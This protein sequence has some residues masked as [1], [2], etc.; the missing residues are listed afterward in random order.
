VPAFGDNKECP[1]YQIYGRICIDDH[2][3]NRPRV[4]GAYRVGG[5]AA[6]PS[7][8]RDESSADRIGDDHEHDRHGVG[9]L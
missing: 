1:R 8:A 7:S 5:I 2:E 6:R 4:S 3:G 9:Y